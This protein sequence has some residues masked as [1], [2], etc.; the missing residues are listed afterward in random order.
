M[1]LKSSILLHE[2]DIEELHNETGCKLKEFCWQM[3]N[4]LP[5]D[6]HFLNRFSLQV[7]I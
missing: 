5:W 3:H 6:V 2:E 4:A 1:G 7:I